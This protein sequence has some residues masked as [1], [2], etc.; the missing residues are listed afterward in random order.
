M[1][2]NAEYADFEAFYRERKNLTG[3]IKFLDSLHGPGKWGEDE[4]RQYL[5]DLYEGSITTEVQSVA[6][7]ELVAKITEYMQYITNPSPGDRMMLERLAFIDLT[8]SKIQ[9]QMVKE[10]TLN[11]TQIQKFIKIQS[12]LSKEAAD[13]QKSLGIDRATLQ[14]MSGGEDMAAYIQ[15]VVRQSAE[16]LREHTIPI[17]CPFCRAEPAEVNINMGYIL[18]HFADDVQWEFTAK[19]PRCG[20]SF[21]I[22]S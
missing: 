8:L 22:G 17:R 20:Q 15:H 10:E 16:F 4:R 14:K 2:D 9:R 11:A 18:F 5:R 1:A 6:A 3:T 19:C 21:R 13:I 12:A 7:R